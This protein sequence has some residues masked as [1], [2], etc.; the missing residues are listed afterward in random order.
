MAADASAQI[1]LTVD[2]RACLTFGEE[3]ELFDVT[4]A[5]VR[6][7]LAG[8]LAQRRRARV[9]GIRAVPAGNRGGAGDGLRADDG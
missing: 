2:D 5:F 3:D 7:G 1:T 4:A 9:S 6:D 8:G